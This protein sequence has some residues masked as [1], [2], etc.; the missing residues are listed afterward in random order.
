MVSKKVFFIYSLIAFLV[1]SPIFLLFY[2][3]K[4]FCCMKL[5]KKNYIINS[6][7]GLSVIDEFRP[8][9]E[10]NIKIGSIKGG[11]NNCLAK[12]TINNKRVL[13]FKKYTVFGTFLTW[14]GNSFSPFRNFRKIP[15]RERIKIETH[16]SKLLRENDIKTPEVLKHD[17][18]N[19]V[20]I[21]DFLEGRL[22][23]R[24]TVTDDLL[25]KI[26]QIVAKIH[27]LGVYINDNTV[28]NYILKGDDIYIIDLE[29]FSENGDRKWDL[30]LFLFCIEENSN[31]DSFLKGYNESNVVESIN[32][33]DISALLDLLHFYKGVSKIEPHLRKKI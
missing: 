3:M 11:F 7:N 29:G 26:G 22:I 17:E 33:E 12:I 1:F 10:N 32:K 27:S 31:K 28:A 4:F 23:D 21:I 15:A 24:I 25:Y 8:I 2:I 18:K 30:V 14:W 6:L 5:N 20:L 19:N 16:Y 13:L 9:N